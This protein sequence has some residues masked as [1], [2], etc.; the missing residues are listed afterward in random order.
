MN[1]LSTL[2]I[3][4]IKEKLIKFKTELFKNNNRIK[5]DLNEYKTIK[6]IG[7]LFNEYEKKKSDLCKAEKMKNL[8]VTKIKNI[9]MNTKVL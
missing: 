5:K 1:S 6:Y 8:A 7:Y 3:K 2:D 4:N 9:L